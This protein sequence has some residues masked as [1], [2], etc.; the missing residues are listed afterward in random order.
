MGRLHLPRLQQISFAE[1]LVMWD[2]HWHVLERQRLEPATDLSDAMAAAI[3]RLAGE[4]WQA[5]ATPEY[6]FVFIRR[7]GERRALDVDAARS[8]RHGGAVVQSVSIVVGSAAAE[9]YVASFSGSKR[10]Y[11]RLTTA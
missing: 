1:L 3:E 11:S 2:L 5:E 4:G 7:E 8:V 10:S 9:S 6:G